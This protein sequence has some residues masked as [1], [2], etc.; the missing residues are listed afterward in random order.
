MRVHNRA[1]NPELPAWDGFATSGSHGRAR[2]ARLL[3]AGA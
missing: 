3:C 2:G 1:G